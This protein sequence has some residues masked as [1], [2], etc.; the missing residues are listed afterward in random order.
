MLIKF[1]LNG[2]HVVCKY[3]IHTILVVSSS[4]NG[5]ITIEDY[6]YHNSVSYTVKII[7]TYTLLQKLNIILYV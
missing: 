4:I 1:N 5:K 2:I 3:C 7:S 6:N